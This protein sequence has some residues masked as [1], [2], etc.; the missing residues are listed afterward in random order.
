MSHTFTEAEIRQVANGLRKQVGWADP[1][2]GKRKLGAR[3]LA[4][5]MLDAYAAS[6]TQTAD[7]AYCDTSGDPIFGAI[8]DAS[9]EET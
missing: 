3:R 6:L 4:A 5:D 9:T 8:T 7:E 2:P 1:P